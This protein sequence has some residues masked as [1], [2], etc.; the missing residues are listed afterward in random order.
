MTNAEFLAH[1][2]IPGMKWGRRK[3]ETTTGKGKANPS[4]KLSDAELQAKVNRLR[5]EQQLKDLSSGSKSGGK[6]YAQQLLK[7]SGSVFV[8]VAASAVS[9]KIVKAALKG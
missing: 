3:G 8:G 6:T 9:A 7:Q 5:L 1:Y 4:A 2:G